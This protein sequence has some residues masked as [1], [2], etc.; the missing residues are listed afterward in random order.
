VDQD[1]PTQLGMLLRIAHVRAARTGNEALR[2]LGIE[3]RHLGVLLM[4]DREGPLSQT[5]IGAQLGADKSQMGRSV[6]DLERLGLAV[7]RADPQDRRTRQVSL[8]PEGEEMLA[9]AKKAAAGAAGEIFQALSTGEQATLRDLL[10]RIARDRQA[11][12]TID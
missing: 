12:T 8:T 3:T 4:L 1:L 10:S 2:P 11:A 6:D 9:R 5:R 7:R